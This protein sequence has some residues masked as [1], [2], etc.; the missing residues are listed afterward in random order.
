[1]IDARSKE[2]LRFLH[3]NP[4][5]RSRIRASPDHTLLYAGHFFK[6]A[7][8]EIEGRRIG[9][10][11][12]RGK[13]I[14]PDIL[15]GIHVPSYP[16]LLVWAQDIDLIE[17]WREN[18][19]VVWRA[20]SGVFAANAVGKVSFYIGEGVDRSKVFAAT[21]LAVLDRNRSI[22]PLTKDL[23]AYYRRCVATPQTEINFAFIR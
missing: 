19:F 22:D 3:D 21:E 11:Q 18:G 23:I 8:Q 20:L 2:L 1:M 12:L 13:T 5:V 4:A 10:P 17:P 16:N 6:P 9:D 7:W 15:R 14:L